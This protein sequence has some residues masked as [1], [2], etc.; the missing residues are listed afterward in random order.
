MGM[1]TLQS[2]PGIL[3]ARNYVSCLTIRNGSPA[4]K[5]AETSPAGS[6]NYWTNACLLGCTIHQVEELASELLQQHHCPDDGVIDPDYQAPLHE[7][8][9]SIVRG[10]VRREVVPF[11]RPIV[12]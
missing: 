10:A 2:L 7:V 5:C 8:A 3:G 1:R 4:V 9:D 12:T 6:P 11:L